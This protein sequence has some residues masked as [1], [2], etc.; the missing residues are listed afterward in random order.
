M[1]SYK[2]FNREIKGYV[3]VIYDVIKNVNITTYLS[4]SRHYN[5]L[6]NYSLTKFEHSQD[7]EETYQTERILPKYAVLSN[8]FTLLDG[9]FILFNKT[10][11][12]SGFYSKNT[13]DY[14]IDYIEE[15]GYEA[16]D[17]ILEIGSRNELINGDA[18]G[19]TVYTQ[20][21]NFV[22]SI[23]GNEVFAELYDG[24]GTLIETSYNLKFYNNQFF[25]AF[26]NNINYCYIKI[27]GFEF[28]YTDR[29][30]IITHIDLGISHLYIDDELIEFTVTEEV[31]K[32]VEE[33]P[34]NEL[35]VTIGDY[36]NL[37]DPL[38]K[39]GIAN[40]LTEKVKYIPYIG[41]V[42][43]GQTIYTKMG[44]FFFNSID[45]QDKQVTITA[46][47]LMDELSSVMIK[48]TNGSLAGTTFWFYGNTL[49]SRLETF[50]SN[51]YEYDYE[52]N[53]SNELLMLILRLPYES[54]AT[55]LQQA[56]MLD[57]IFYID[58]DNKI[59]VREINKTIIESLSKNELL[60]DINYVNV[61]NYKSYYMDISRIGSFGASST[62]NTKDNFSV[63]FT[64][65][66]EV[67]E[68]CVTS[69]APEDLAAI[70]TDDLTYTGA[71]SV[72]VLG[73][74]NES[75][76]ETGK[77]TNQFIYM[78]FLKVTGTPG[79]EVTITGKKTYVTEF[80]NETTYPKLMGDDETTNISITNPL[81]YSY[82]KSQKFIDKMYSYEVSCEYNGN[83]NIKAGDYIQ[84]ES[85]YGYIPIFVQKHTLTFNGG[86][87][88]SI[89]GVE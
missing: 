31:N 24:D 18:Y 47:N 13:I 9:S 78:L 3:E 11:N 81:I 46:Y 56:S 74:S 39:E 34:T 36:G 76:S 19:V 21:N 16:R 50:L 30:A 44:E 32:L 71:T 48:N 73:Y 57:G 40:Y 45:Y 64:L 10:S 61:K 53:I 20:N 29:P 28:E 62:L 55:F 12:N 60:K 41:I 58:R 54:L 15:N 23:H 8:N 33:T 1:T 22:K 26:E 25:I 86:L 38:N 82:N 77:K 79:T 84:I 4:I 87:S 14:Y 65:T 2:D 63:T 67:E 17:F 42:S 89:E 51:C 37:Y 68:I 72:D 69:D 88:G 75:T 49:K 6:S 59:V 52:I 5:Y 27:K 7:L 85:N 66:K 35:D 70:S 43:D 80:E 83:P